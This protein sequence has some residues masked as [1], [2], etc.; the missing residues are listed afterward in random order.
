M[1]K[2]L[3]PFSAASHLSPAPQ[4]PPPGIDPG[5][6]QTR[7]METDSWG[8]KGQTSPSPTLV[9]GSLT[10]TQFSMSWDEARDGAGRVA[11]EKKE[12]PLPQLERGL[13]RRD[14]QWSAYFFSSPPNSAAPRGPT[15]P[16]LPGA[17]TLKA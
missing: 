10:P 15:T 14:L 16:A 9:T 4:W 6:A 12:D 1:S 17:S 8:Q 2:G 3:S 7:E 5:E 13:Q 11:R